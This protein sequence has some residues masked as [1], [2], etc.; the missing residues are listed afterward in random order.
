MRYTSASVRHVDVRVR[1]IRDQDV[2]VFE[3]A[4]RHV[5]VQVEAR[6]HRDRVPH[7]RT[8]AREQLALAVVQ[9]LG[10]HGA[11]QVQIHRVQRAGAA[12]R[13]DDHAGDSLECFLGDV[14]RRAG[15]RPRSRQKL[16]P[17]ALH[18]LDET[19]DRQVDA[20][21]T[22]EYVLP[23]QQRRPAAAAHELF[24]GRLAR[25]KSIG[26]VLETADGDT[27]F[28]SLLSESIVL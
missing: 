16:M 15:R 23:A 5:R 11:V 3:H 2:G 17:A 22:F 26:L 8:Y 21:H 24:I 7:H 10:H 18:A 12:D 14:R 4:L 27:H 6:N 20:G 28:Y 25:R 13:L 1:A 19:R 9:M